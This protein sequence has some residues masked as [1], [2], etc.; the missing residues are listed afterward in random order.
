M[1]YG[2]HGSRDER[3]Q[4]QRFP[5]VLVMRCN[6]AS[7]SGCILDP[8]GICIHVHDVQRRYIQSLPVY[9]YIICTAD[10]QS[11]HLCTGYDV[12]NTYCIQSHYL[13]TCISFIQH[14]YRLP[15]RIL[16]TTH[17]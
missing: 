13:Y 9:R 5:R 8:P 7:A 14:I 16:H 1:C 15:T 11:H 2:L 3:Q 17:I 12:H 10:I 6:P 4:Q